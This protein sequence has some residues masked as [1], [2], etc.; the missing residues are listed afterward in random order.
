MSTALEYAFNN[1]VRYNNPELPPIGPGAEEEN[2]YIALQV[3]LS[4]RW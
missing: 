3:M 1:A 2:E 4:R